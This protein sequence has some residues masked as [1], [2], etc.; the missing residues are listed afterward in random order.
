VTRGKRNKIN[1]AYVVIFTNSLTRGAEYWVRGKVE[2]TSVSFH[3]ST[4]W[5]R[6]PRQPAA[7][8]KRLYKLT[9]IL[10]QNA[11]Y[12]QVKFNSTSKPS[13]T[14]GSEVSHKYRQRH[15]LPQTHLPHVSKS[16]EKQPNSVTTPK[17]TYWLNYG[18]EPQRQY[19]ILVLIRAEPL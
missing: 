5:T 6:R 2:I 8:L 18:L 10:W 14:S 12:S 17:K 9:T 19:G 7:V 16:F 3:T 15:E 4:K 13:P 1:W 11:A